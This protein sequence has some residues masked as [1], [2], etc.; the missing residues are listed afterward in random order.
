[1]APVAFP[2]SHRF[3]SFVSFRLRFLRLRGFIL[4]HP[5]QMSLFLIFSRLLCS[6]QFTG[7]P[8]RC[9][10]PTRRHRPWRLHMVQVTAMRTCPHGSPGSGVCTSARTASPSAWLVRSG[11]RQSSAFALHSSTIS[12]ILAVVGD[13]SIY[14]TINRDFQPMYHDFRPIFEKIPKS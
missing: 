1:L 7:N 4:L 10:P 11:L 3:G 9:S 6:L 12:A 13:L 5:A 8:S 14:R 2:D